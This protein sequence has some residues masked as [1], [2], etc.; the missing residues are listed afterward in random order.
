MIATER[1]V[2]R[3][4]EDRDRP[5]FY[6]HCADLEVMRYFPAPMT[7]AEVDAAIDRQDGY[8]ATHGYCF[9]VVEAR[10]TATMIGFCGLKPGAEDTPLEGGVEIGWRFGKEY[11]GQGLARE[12]AMASLDWG[13]ANLG[14]DRIGAITAA[15][16]I[17]SWGLMERL[18]MVRSRPEDFDHPAVPDDSPLKRH[19]TYWKTRP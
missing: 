1:L 18:G 7:P 14:V 17:R 4:W 19:I 9:W 5:I 10:A 8:Q 12:A 15:T 3:R 13:F 6:S 11:W 2:L 16:N